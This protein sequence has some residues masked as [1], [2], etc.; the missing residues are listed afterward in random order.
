MTLVLVRLVAA[1]YLDPLAQ[2]WMLPP[3]PRSCPPSNPPYPTGQWPFI[4]VYCFF[5][6]WSLLS[7]R[8]EM[9]KISTKM[10]GL[11]SS[12]SPQSN[13]NIARIANT[14]CLESQQNTPYIGQS[15]L[16]SLSFFP[17]YTDICPPDLK[18]RAKYVGEWVQCSSFL[19]CVATK[20]L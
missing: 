19:Q 13:I 1:A 11:N 5:N 15:L 14:A 7:K 4:S 6:S 16:Q 10:N 3:Y 17:A 8:L 2:G 20:W 9:I 18:G 12:S